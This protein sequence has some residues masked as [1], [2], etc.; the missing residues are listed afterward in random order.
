MVEIGEGLITDIQNLQWIYAESTNKHQEYK[1]ETQM[2]DEG[3]NG[4]TGQ[5]SKKKKKITNKKF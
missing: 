1:K 5:G 3:F 4:K 2:N